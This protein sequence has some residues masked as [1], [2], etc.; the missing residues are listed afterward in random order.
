MHNKSVSIPFCVFAVMKNKLL[1]SLLKRKCDKFKLFDIQNP[2]AAA[3]I[4]QWMYLLI[5]VY[6]RVLLKTQ[7]LISLSSR[8]LLVAYWCE[9]ITRKI[10]LKYINI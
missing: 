10:L 6:I 9:I 5:R 3:H 2:P 4:L 8:V 7:C 1:Y